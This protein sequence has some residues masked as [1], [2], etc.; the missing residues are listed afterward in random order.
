MAEAVIDAL[1]ERLKLRVTRSEAVR[2]AEL[3]AYGVSGRVGTDEN[4]VGLEFTWIA[5]EDR[6][7]QITGIAPVDRQE[8]LVAIR[9]TARSFR[10][11]PPAD[12]ELER[13]V[14]RDL[15]DT[16]P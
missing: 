6:L 15:G 8:H 2:I 7:Y 3:P 14:D 11:P 12:P 4:A 1:S 5:Y 9:E 13:I 10:P 16:A